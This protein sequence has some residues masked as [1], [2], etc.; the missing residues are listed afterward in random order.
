MNS[1][2]AVST[3]WSI[4]P[5]PGR[6][7]ICECQHRSIKS[8]IPVDSPKA[9]PSVGRGGRSPRET[10]L[11]TAGSNITSWNGIFPV[12]SFIRRDRHQSRSIEHRIGAYLPGYHSKSIDITC[13]TGRCRRLVI[14]KFWGHPPRRACF[15]HCRRDIDDLRYTGI[16][17]DYSQTEVCQPSFEI[18]VDKNIDL[19]P[20]LI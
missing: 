1:A 15:F 10:L 18:V 4:S 13:G 8:H 17:A 3:T 9:V 2:Q 6:E 12:K 5:V 19:N 11:T 16:G 20:F 14:K 7:S